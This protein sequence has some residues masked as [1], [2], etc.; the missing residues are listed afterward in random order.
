MHAG[1]SPSELIREAVANAFDMDDVTEVYVKY[2]QGLIVIEDNSPTGIG[3][4][5]LVTTIFLT[6]KTDSHTKRG[7]KGRGLKELIAA[8]HTATI[9]TVGHTIE[10]TEGRTVKTNNRLV[11]TRVSIYAPTWSA[12]DIRD[13]FKYLLR[14][15]PPKHIRF[16]VMSQEIERRNIK[17]TFTRTFETQ[18]IEDGIQKDVYK[19]ADVN[20]VE[21]NGSDDKGWIYEMGIPIQEISTNF[22]IDVQQRVPLNDNRNNVSSWYLNN[23]YAEVLNATISTMSATDLKSEWAI[24]SL[25]SATNNTRRTFIEKAFG[26]TKSIAIKSK[27]ARANDLVQQHGV[28]VVDTSNMP[29][30][31]ESAVREVVSTADTMADEIEQSTQDVI[32]SQDVAD[33]DGKIVRLTKYLGR[34]LINMD[35]D[36]QFISRD[37]SVTGHMRR[38]DFTSDTGLIRFNVKANIKPMTSDYFGL[39]CHEFTHAKCSGHDDDFRAELE[40]ISGALAMLLIVRSAEILE[41]IAQSSVPVPN[42]KVRIKCDQCAS[43][44]DVAP[45]DAHKIRKCLPCIKRART[46]RATMRRAERRRD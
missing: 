18:I 25:S 9:E 3:D 36:V 8:A 34:Q 29:Y 12:D 5:D 32:I 37:K 16:F 30:S 46:A 26:T 41:L 19:S 38:A 24:T 6:G 45:Y 40:R 21:L 22:H 17:C 13:A 4:P 39:I 44:R 31:V 1:R 42:G 11:G 33:P 35:L 20:I 7:R 28:K 43:P 14:F 2:D 10:F 23:M 27:N 15:I